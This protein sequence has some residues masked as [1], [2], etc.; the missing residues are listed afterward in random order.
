MCTR[1]SVT[2]FRKRFVS[3]MA[4]QTFWE[5]IVSLK[6]RHT[7]FCADENKV[8]F[9][10]LDQIHHIIVSYVD[11]LSFSIIYG[12]SSICSLYITQIALIHGRIF[13]SSTKV[14][15]NLIQS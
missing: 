13:L 5:V 2:Y 12:I 4:L 10:I 8:P 3:L 14:D 1:D 11:V 6:N 7:S 15:E 9:L